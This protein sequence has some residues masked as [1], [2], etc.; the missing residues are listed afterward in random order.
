M[1]LLKWIGLGISIWAVSLVW[2]EVNLGLSVPVMVGLVG[3]SGLGLMMVGLLALLEQHL[4]RGLAQPTSTVHRQ[5]ETSPP[6]WHAQPT[7]PMLG[8]VIRHN[9]ASRPT[10]PVAI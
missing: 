8:A 1:K 7:R 5:V 10:R 6:V 3:L 2:P 4:D 9:T